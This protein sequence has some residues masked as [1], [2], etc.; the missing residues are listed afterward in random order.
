MFNV[1]KLI[2][3]LVPIVL[4]GMSTS[5]SPTLQACPFCSAVSQTFS[6]EIHTM[7]VVVVCELQTIG[8]YNPEANTDPQ[9]E[10]PKSTFLIRK[11]IKGGEYIKDGDTFQ[12][13]YFGEPKKGRPFLAMAT[14][15][16]KLQWSTPLI[17]T[18]RAETYLAELQKINGT[19]QNKMID[20]LRLQ[21][22]ELKK[23]LQGQKGKEL[24]ANGLEAQKRIDEID[25][26]LEG[27]VL[28]VGVERLEFF[29]DYLED[30]DEMLARD[31]YDE[32]AKAPYDAV[33]MLEPKMNHDRLVSFIK[34][35]DVPSNRRRLYFTMLGVCGTKADAAM[36][37]EF[38][39]SDDRKKKAGLDALIACHLILTGEQ[40]LDRVEDQFLK[41][42]DAEYADTYAAIM[43][44]RFHGSEVDVIP[45]TRLTKSL[46]HML[47]RPELAD[48]VIPDLAKWED[49][50]VM[51]K[52]VDLFATADENSSW[53]RVPVVNYLRSC[54]LPVA[55][56]KI[57]VLKTI[58][59]EAV[60]RAM[61]FFPMSA[62]P[63]DEEESE[64]TAEAD[65]VSQGLSPAETT[66][67]AESLKSATSNDLADDS[68]S[69]TIQAASAATN[70]AVETN[71]TD[72]A[73]LAE[74]KKT[75]SFTTARVKDS[76]SEVSI[77]PPDTLNEV[78]SEAEK[79]PNFLKLLGVMMLCGAV[80]LVAMRTALGTN[81]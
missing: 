31:A 4:L 70:T 17:L 12:C 55:E 45:R 75:N 49:W 16:P 37:E 38:M 39:M 32:F 59:A 66:A 57:E 62:D 69:P 74:T 23:S 18:D 15:A 26:E 5:A 64:A 73:Q 53:V 22:E 33:K 20:E 24:D 29:Q 52:L 14:D 34:N 35:P 68:V 50:T 6:E 40:G 77:V 27:L 44:I 28:T 48:L 1:R 19:V 7:D 10:I 56:E 36:L 81:S 54:P 63:K 76:N 72:V 30:E 11:V 61:T 51:N 8:K 46:H 78:E 2:R 58:D 42:K 13:V 47:E 65:K 67:V 80:C 71:E 79:G 9:A 60:K 3:L 41:N 25:A 43:A 21:K